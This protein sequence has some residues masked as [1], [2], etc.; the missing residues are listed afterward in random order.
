MLTVGICQLHRLYGAVYALRT[1]VKA[2]E[3]REYAQR[4]EHNNS[5]AVRRQLPDA[6]ASVVD[7]HGLDPLWL[8]G[9]EVVISE[10]PAAAPAPI[11]YPARQLAAIKA[12]AVRGGQLAQRLTELRQLH[13][14]TGARRLAV[15]CKRI[16]PGR[17]FRL[18][19]QRPEGGVVVRPETRH[20]RRDRVAIFGVADC[21]GEQLGKWQTPEPAA[22]LGPCGGDTRHVHTV[23]ALCGYFAEALAQENRVGQSR[24]RA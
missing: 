15:Y 24:G 22:G 17:N 12:L 16:E 23:P 9:R 3:T 10:P 21:T 1:P 8:I 6:V 13:D 18:A 5:M 11:V 14:L 20:H 7:G 19:A 4:H 2:L